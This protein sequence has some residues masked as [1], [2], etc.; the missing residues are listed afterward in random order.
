MCT[1]ILDLGVSNTCMMR[2]ILKER[3]ISR[4]QAYQKL[5]VIPFQS[6]R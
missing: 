5:Q 2:Y 4:K 3:M 6:R 1:S